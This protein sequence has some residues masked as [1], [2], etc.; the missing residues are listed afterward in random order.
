MPSVLQLCFAYP[1]KDGSIKYVQ[2][3]NKETNEPT[4]F[5]VSRDAAYKIVA[6]V[7]ERRTE[8]RKRQFAEA[9]LLLLQY[10]ARRRGRRPSHSAV[11]GQ[12]DW[13][14]KDVA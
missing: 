1:Q 5:E 3:H 6:D 8:K 11:P 4:A 2:M 9:K 10:R 7:Y 13:L 14:K 12:L